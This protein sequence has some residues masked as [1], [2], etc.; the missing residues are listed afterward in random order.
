V[1]VDEI[2][3][4]CVKKEKH[5]AVYEIKDHRIGD[6]YTFIGLEA[7][8]KLVLCFEMGKRDGMT[9]LR[10][11]EKLRDATSGVFQL[12]SDGFR[13]YIGAVET[14]FGAGIHFA[15]L[16]KIYS[17]DESTRERYS[18]GEVVDAIPV[19]ITGSPKPEKISTSFVE[20]FN[21]TLRM[22]MRRLTRL[23]NGFSK[24]WENLHSA[25]S[26]M[27]AHYNFC[28]V[29]QTLRVTP[30]MAAGITSEVWTLD[31]LLI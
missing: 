28:R 26:L 12:T 1:Q 15:Q 4:Y 10:F 20:R 22:Q 23:T 19:P 16:V 5:K 11:I 29:H 14:V 3:A 7:K 13:P 9:T 24:K 31:K 21:L 30:A 18:P 6:A 17:S 8:S 27:I 25:M 2:W